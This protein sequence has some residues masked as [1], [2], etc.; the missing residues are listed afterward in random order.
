[1]G[2]GA[3]AGKEAGFWLGR[4]GGQWGPFSALE[5]EAARHSVSPAKH[6]RKNDISWLLL[7]SIALMVACSTVQVSAQHSCA[8]WGRLNALSGFVSKYVKGDAC[9]MDPT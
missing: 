9:S 6:T 7:I 1:M 2:F 4:Q 3:G 5:S 8:D